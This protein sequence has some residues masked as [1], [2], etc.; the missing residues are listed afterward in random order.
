MNCNNITP[1]QRQRMTKRFAEAAEKW[2]F[3]PINPNKDFI[4]PPIGLMPKTIHDERVNRDRLNEV[5][6]AITRYID[7][8]L[9]VSV[10]WIE[11]YNELIESAP[12]MCD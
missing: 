10:E 12:R 8:G 3:D 1:E 5:R 2:S 9:K 7:A 6:S 11:E 4:K